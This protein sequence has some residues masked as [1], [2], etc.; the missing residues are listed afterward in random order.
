[1]Y[2]HYILAA[3]ISLSTG[4]L[5]QSLVLIPLGTWYNALGGADTGL[6][7][8]NFV[9]AAGI[10]SFASG[11]ME[12][13]LGTPLEMTRPL[14]EWFGILALVIMLT[15]QTQD[16][17]DMEGDASR[18]R[19]TMPL[20]V[21]EALARWSTAITV[22]AFSGICP[23]YWCLKWHGFVV[24]ITLGSI[25]AIRLLS[26]RTIEADKM[27]WRIWNTWM[28]ALYSLPLLRVLISSCL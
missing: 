1:M 23:T 11:A 7:T 25:V 6:M 22:V 18:N 12:V 24:P 15:V 2:A 17:A 5:S 26:Y 21:G 16:F 9:N 8:R 10:L 20:V 4:G 14:V 27:T 19:K 3:L 13:I 28:V